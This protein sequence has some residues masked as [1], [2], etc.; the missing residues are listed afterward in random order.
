MFLS[1]YLIILLLSAIFSPSAFTSPV[2]QTASLT[3]NLSITKPSNL[4][5]ISNSN[6]HCIDLLNPF[7]RRPKYAD[8]TIAIRQLPQNPAF[9]AFHNHG[10]DDPFKLPV[11]KT[12]SSCTVRIELNA[13]SSR[14]GAS[15]PGISTKTTELNRRC[16]RTTFPIYKGGWATYAK[17]DRIVISLNY[18]DRSGG[19]G[20][21]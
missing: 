2:P 11:E 5:S 21:V 14:V 19:E 8:C 7:S 16:L 18:P 4:T 20:R 1:T 10:T 12:Y 6:T 13:G 17:Y 3:S 15:W 9:G